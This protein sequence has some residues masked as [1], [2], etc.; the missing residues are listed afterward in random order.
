MD[1]LQE[2]TLLSKARVGMLTDDI[3]HCLA[4]GIVK[5]SIPVWWLVFKVV[6]KL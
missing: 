2:I 4:R 1:N 5:K 3:V 6:R